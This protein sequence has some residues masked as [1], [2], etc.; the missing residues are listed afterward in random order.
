[1][2]E[3]RR[4]ELKPKHTRI[5]PGGPVM[6]F[7]RRVCVKKSDDGRILG[8]YITLPMKKMREI[9][10]HP[11]APGERV[12]MTIQW[13]GRSVTWDGVVRVKRREKQEK[14]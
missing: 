4:K 1:M 8:E 11:I 3:E 12:H 10:G 13:L 14:F 2:A 9:Y 7:E 6:T 5:T